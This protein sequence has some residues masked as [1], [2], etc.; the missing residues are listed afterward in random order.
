MRSRR[1]DLWTLRLDCD[2]IHGTVPTLDIVNDVLEQHLSASDEGLCSARGAMTP[3]VRAERDREVYGSRLGAALAAGSMTPISVKQP[4]MVPQLEVDGLL[5]ALDE[6]RAQLVRVHDGSRAAQIAAT[7]G[8]SQAELP[9]LRADAI[10]V[11]R[12]FGSDA[13]SFASDPPDASRIAEALRLTHEELASVLATRFVRADGAAVR[14]RTTRTAGA[15]QPDREVVD[16]LTA[17]ALGRLHRFVRLWRRTKARQRARL[18]LG[19]LFDGASGATSFQTSSSMGSIASDRAAAPREG[20]DRLG[21]PGCVRRTLP[22]GPP[23][24]GAASLW[25]GASAGSPLAPTPIP[26]RDACDRRRR[27]RREADRAPLGRCAVPADI[28]AT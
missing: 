8:T 7:L 28:L 15:A 2:A 11:T 10:D 4:S 14:L 9:L 22:R 5:R 26:P 25:I 17:D 23:T 19:A 13:R 16:G 18:L 3:A 1:P 20:F 24:E 6:E 21:R 12:L 27:T